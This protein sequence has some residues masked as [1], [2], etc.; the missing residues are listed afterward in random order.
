MFYAPLHGEAQ[1]AASVVSPLTLMAHS[2]QSRRGQSRCATGPL[3]LRTTVDK[4][5]T[6]S[7]R[8]PLPRRAIKSRQDAAPCALGRAR[9]ALLARDGG[10]S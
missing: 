3:R 2:A 4:P 7:V 5:A 8:N 1:A 6:A 10:A 9:R